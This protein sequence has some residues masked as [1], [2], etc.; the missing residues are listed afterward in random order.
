MT[1]IFKDLRTAAHNRVAYMRTVRE[2]E[3][4]PLNT[5]IDLDIYPPDARKIA[6]K[7]VYG[8]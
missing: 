4:M 5:A 8:R 3:S 2:I 6:R 1:G 7:A